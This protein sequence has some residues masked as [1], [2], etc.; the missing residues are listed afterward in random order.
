MKMQLTTAL[1]ILVLLS[2]GVARAQAT[3]DDGPLAAAADVVLVRPA[4]LA[5]TAIGSALFVVALPFAALSKS[6]KRTADTLVGKPAR[7][8]FTRPVGD[9]TTLTP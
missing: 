3:N 2:P 5:A 8:T 6:V 4:C 9:F 7:A 1:C